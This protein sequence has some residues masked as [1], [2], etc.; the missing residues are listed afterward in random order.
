MGMILPGATANGANGLE[1]IK[2]AG[3][4]TTARAVQDILTLARNPR[5][6]HS[7]AGDE[8]LP[9]RPKALDKIFQLLKTT[10]NVDFGL[11]R[12]PSINRRIRQ[13]MLIP[14]LQMKH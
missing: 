1:T 7:K 11:Y 14:K 8:L 10:T 9:K 5:A 4:I 12:E 6:A 2:D 3:P 13:R